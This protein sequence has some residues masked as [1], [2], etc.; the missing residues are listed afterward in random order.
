MASWR[1]LA[2]APAVSGLSFRGFRGPEDYPTMVELLNAASAADG[3][4]RF[5]TLEDMRL[6]YEHL[7]NSD[8][9]TDVVIAEID[10]RPVA[11]GRVLWWEENQGPIRYSPFC[12]VH[13]DGRGKGIGTA[14]LAH[15]EALLRRVAAGHDPGRERTL[16]VDHAD[17]EAAAAALYEQ[18]GYRPVEFHATLV[19]PDLEDIPEA[20]MPA[21][22]IVRT[23]AEDEMRRVW[24]SEAEA[25][26][27]H[28]GASDPTENDYEQFLASPWRDP[29]LWRIAWDGDQVAGGVRSYINE[30]ENAQFGRKRG[31]T[32]NISVRR[33]YRRRGLARALLVQSLHAVKER[34]MEEAALGVHTGN[35][36][37]AFDLYQSV[38]FRVT[39]MWTELHKPLD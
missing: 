23:P 4:E 22:F 12:F 16:R 27:D 34:G 15:N 14:M 35:P 30:D 38:G 26:R 33:P 20:P 6:Q 19:R 1:F 7:D 24:D 32:E 10:G 21:G 8:P 25:F 29:T 36:N 5:V 13:P 31:W 39:Q 9:S 2:D 18:A 17:T 28:V 11:Y 37:G 3:I